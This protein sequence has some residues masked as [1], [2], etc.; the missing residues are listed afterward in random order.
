MQA[1]N[2]NEEYIKLREVINRL[3][4]DGYK[5][6]N[7]LQ[8][9]IGDPATPPVKIL[10]GVLA[11][12]KDMNDEKKE[13]IYDFCLKSIQGGKLKFDETLV[14][15]PKPESQDFHELDLTYSTVE[16]LQSGIH[17]CFSVLAGIVNFR[18]D[19]A[20][21]TPIFKTA[22][23]DFVITLSFNC[24]GKTDQ[25]K[26][27]LK[28]IVQCLIAFT[29]LNS[30]AFKINGCFENS[31]DIVGDNVVL[32]IKAKPS[33]KPILNCVYDLARCLIP[34]DG[35]KD[36]IECNYDLNS[37]CEKLVADLNTPLKELIKQCVVKYKANINRE[38]RR[39]MFRF[40]DKL[41]EEEKEALMFTKLVRG[42]AGK[43]KIQH[44]LPKPR[45]EV[46]GSHEVVV[47]EAI[48]ELK[49]S[50]QLKTPMEMP[51]FKKIFS[52]FSEKVDNAEFRIFVPNFSIKI[53]ATMK[54][55]DKLLN[56]MV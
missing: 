12:G 20:K 45:V 22:E 55:L 48:K 40:L 39:V 27:A 33:I 56:A 17:F 8:K 7:P 38:H 47:G 49:Q 37:E 14:N 54:N 32:C 36:S 18:E 46:Q 41:L 11:F 43:L 3:N 13:A 25:V 16:H 2:P 29:Y 34:I 9:I 26:V 19:F 51:I 15:L 35:E 1:K 21:L 44:E 53:G 42:F 30:L 50:G 10:D 28:D 5:G 24:P 52:F 23:D 31:V 6:D 4:K